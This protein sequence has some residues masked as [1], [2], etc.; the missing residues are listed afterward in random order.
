MPITG[1]NRVLVKN[2]LMKLQEDPHPSLDALMSESEV[3]RQKLSTATFGFQIGPPLNAAGRLDS[4][5][6]SFFLL[7]GKKE[8]ASKLVSANKDRQGLMK[9]GITEA[10]KMIG[11]IGDLRMLI[12]KNKNWG[13][14]II[15]LIA[16]KIAEK[17]HRP[18][19]VLSERQGEL[20]GSA[21]SI[22]GY[23][24]IEALTRH[25]EL[26]IHFGGHAQ[27]A[28][29]S[30]A[31]EKYDEFMDVMEQDAY[32]HIQ[33]SD[34]VPTL[35]IDTEIQ[36]EEV[37]FKSVEE[38][39]RLEPFG[40][41]NAKPLLLMRDIAV[42]NIKTVGKDVEHV[43]FFARFRR[44]AQ[45]GRLYETRAIAFG[46]G[47]HADLLNSDKKFDLVVQVETDDW[48]GQRGCS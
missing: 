16:S 42:E 30:L 9:H 7:T 40:L 47:K 32:D 8:L 27:A 24:I 48:K 17:F 2:G 18:S 15:G 6:D 46:F 38:L 21:R 28:G 22:S 43:S 13:I 5:L 19:L 39:S 14:G 36:P 31:P 1:E 45:I 3:D 4:A 29:F 35:R 37:S 44:D 34:L 12:V 33:E 20:V 41:G 23:S 25:K 26:F 11:E 10:E